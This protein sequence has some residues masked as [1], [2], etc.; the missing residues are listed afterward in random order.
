MFN[1]LT[2]DEL[3]TLVQ[4]LIVLQVDTVYDGVE[5]RLQKHL[6]DTSFINPSAF[7]TADETY[8]QACSRLELIDIS[9]GYG[10][11]HEKLQKKELV[12]FLK[13]LPKYK[14]FVPE[15]LQ[16]AEAVVVDTPPRMKCPLGTTTWRTPRLHKLA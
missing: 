10:N 2:D 13:D 3:D 14:T 16:P 1:T 8:L 4:A 11:D 9:V 7:F 15:R 12:G 5:T 6:L